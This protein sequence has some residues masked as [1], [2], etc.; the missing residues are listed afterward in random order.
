VLIFQAPK[1]LGM[2]GGGS[3]TAAS[4]PAVTP[5][6]PGIDLYDS[7]SSC[8]RDTRPGGDRHALTRGL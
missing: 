4:E 3:S 7:G 5:R 1:I 2:F 6:P 8:S